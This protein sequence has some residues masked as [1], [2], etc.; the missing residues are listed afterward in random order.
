MA[1]TK[2]IAAGWHPGRQQSVNGPFLAHW[3]LK[4]GRLLCTEGTLRYQGPK[5]DQPPSVNDVCP[6]CFLAIDSAA[7][8]LG[9]SL[10]DLTERIR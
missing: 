2:P 6:R 10:G 9:L 5:L 4:D 1:D 3:W 7:E 8:R